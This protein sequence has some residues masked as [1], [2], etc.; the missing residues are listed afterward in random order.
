MPMNQVTRTFE[1]FLSKLRIGSPQ[2]LAFGVLMKTLPDFLRFFP[3]CGPVFKLALDETL[4]D[5]SRWFGVDWTV[6]ATHLARYVAMILSLKPMCPRNP[7]QGHLVKNCKVAQSLMGILYQSRFKSVI[8]KSSQCAL[9]V[10]ADVF[11]NL[12]RL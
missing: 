2:Y 12:H 1:L 3:L 9:I 6:L 8:S 10:R 11:V 5:S 4:T 7:H